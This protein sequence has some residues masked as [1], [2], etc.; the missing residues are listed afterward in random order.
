MANRPEAPASYL[1]SLRGW[2]AEATG[3][4]GAGGL[5]AGRRSPAPAEAATDADPLGVVLIVAD[6]LAAA[7]GWPAG[8]VDELHS[9]CCA[10]ARAVRP[11]VPAASWARPE[12]LGQIYETLLAPGLRHR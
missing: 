11:P 1:R 12:L 9:L 2:A 6:Q 7:E 8:V 5:P 10:S 3:A 4:R